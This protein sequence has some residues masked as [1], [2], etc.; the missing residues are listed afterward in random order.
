MNATPSTILQIGQKDDGRAWL[1]ALI[2]TVA[3]AEEDRLSVLKAQAAEGS[4][5]IRYGLLTKQTVV[6][7]F[8][9]I[10]QSA[11]FI[12]EFGP[13]AVQE[14]FAAF[15]DVVS[16]FKARKQGI[17]LDVLDRKTFP[18]LREIVP[19][20]LPEGLSILGGRIKLG[21]SWLMYDVSTAVAYGGHALSSIPVEQGDVLHLALED[22]ERRVQGRLRQMLGDVEKPKRCELHETYARLDQGGLEEIDAWAKDKPNPRLVVIDTL[23]RVRRPRGGSEGWYE[24]DYQSVEPLKALADRYRMAVV[25]VHHLNKQIGAVDPFDLISGSNG[26]AACADST[27]ILDR[28][29]QGVRLYGR[30]RDVEEFEKALSFDKV[31]GRWSILGE[32][33]E[34]HRSDE[35]KSIISVIERAAGPLGPK[36]IAA[37]TRMKD[38]NVRFLLS[39]MVAAGEIKKQGYGRYTPANT[40]HT[41]DTSDGST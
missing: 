30:G 28:D 5:I 9:Q 33:S 41:T 18:E 13:D 31:A 17:T 7:R 36:E 2:S 22:G 34:V 11:G 35:R 8:S 27:L 19:G 26:L 38:G 29:G 32:A 23:V 25:V 4:Q 1:A 21:K 6:D 37:A 10:A 24:Y 39:Q 40:A 3:L 12:D 15:G 14:A 16:A 20:I